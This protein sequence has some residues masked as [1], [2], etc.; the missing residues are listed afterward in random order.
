MT[1]PSP[2]A[3]SSEKFL[4]EIKRL[5]SILERMEEDFPGN[6]HLQRWRQTLPGLAE[7]RR[8]FSLPLTCIGPVKSGKST[9]INTLAA[10]DLLPTGAGITTSFP[11]TVR[12]ARKFSAHIVL[13]SEE[14][15]RGIFDQALKLLFGD[16]LGDSP[17]RL[18][19]S[20]DHSRLLELPR[21]AP[22]QDDRPRRRAFSVGCVG[23]A[24]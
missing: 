22:G 1:K 20:D 24:E 15:I 19:A 13:Q 3:A 6:S 17:P 18:F 16:E 4:S 7:M 9:L 12:A 5:E 10:A 2:P 11:T 21:V 23:A 8:S 14:K